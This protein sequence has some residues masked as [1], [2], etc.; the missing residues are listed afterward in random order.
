MLYHLVPKDFEGDTI[1]P[2]SALKKFLP[3]L[4]QK[5][6]SKYQGRE[7]FPND[8]IPMLGCTWADV[9]CLSAVHPRVLT[10]A[11][12]AGGYRVREPYRAFEIDPSRLNPRLLAVYDFD[13]LRRG[14]YSNFSPQKIEAYATVGDITVE[15][16]RARC[17]ERKSPFLFAGITHILLKGPLA[18]SELPIVSG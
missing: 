8:L 17:L 7:G 10:E 15:Y 1:Y 14:H 12:R 5:Q 4:Y 6:V 11:L 3:I 2:L 18:V 9:V 16:Y 13:D